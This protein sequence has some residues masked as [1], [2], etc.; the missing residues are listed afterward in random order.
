M[1]RSAISESQ[2]ASR[3]VGTSD[4]PTTLRRSAPASCLDL[5][6]WC[7]SSSESDLAP[8]P[9]SFPAP[10]V[11]LSSNDLLDESK[12]LRNEAAKLNP[13]QRRCDPD[14]LRR[15]LCIF[16]KRVAWQVTIGARRWRVV[17]VELRSLSCCA[18]MVSKPACCAAGVVGSSALAR[19]SSAM[20]CNSDARRFAVSC[21]SA[22]R[23]ARILARRCSR[24]CSSGGKSCCC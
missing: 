14:R 11:V 15:G 1:A 12:Q 18:A 9:C 21:W 6:E 23:V 20:C 24:R 17:I 22:S 13:C 16:Q 8:S 4:G 2:S 7:D 3:R 19:S 5:P 10:S